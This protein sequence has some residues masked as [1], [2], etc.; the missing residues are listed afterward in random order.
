MDVFDLVAKLKMDISEYEEGLDKAKKS[1][2]KSGGGI[3]G[4]LSK[5][6]SVGG[7][8]L[9]GLTKVTAAAVGAATA[10]VGALVKSS[11]EA[12]GEYEQLVGGIETLFG[13]GGKSLQEYA[14]SVGKTAEE[15]QGEYDKLL[16]TQK[17]MLDNASNAFRT[18]GLSANEYMNTTIGFSGALLKSVGGDTEKAAEQTHMAITDMADQANKYGKSV[19][20]ISETYT[21]L[22]R[23]NTQTLD[24]LFGGMFAGTKAGLQEMLT[25]AEDYRASLGETVS[26][27][28]DSY[29]DIVSAIHDVSMATGVYGTTALEASTTIQG[30][31][32]MLSAAWQNLVTGLGDKNAD[33][34][35]LIGNVVD[36]L[37]GYTD[38]AGKH[39]NGF[40]DNLLPIIENSL[41]AIGTLVQKL[42]PNA[43]DIIPGLITDV[44]PKLSSA[45]TELVQGMVSALSDNMDTISSVISQVVTSLVKLLPDIIALGGKIATTLGSAIIDNLDI[46]LDAAGQILEMILKG[47][48][49]NA[50]K[51]VDV[52]VQVIEMLAGFFTDNI[53]LVVQS[54]ILIV[55]G[56]AQGLMDNLDVLLAAAF[57]ICTS[58]AEAIL[59]NIDVIISAIPPLIQAFVDSLVKFLPKMTEAWVKLM[60]CIELA[61]PEIIDAILAA[62][63]KLMD[64]LVNYWLGD[65]FQQTFRASVIMFGALTKALGMA[66]LQI[67]ANIGM[68]VRGIGSQIAGEAGN[69]LSSAKTMFMGLVNG[70]ASIAGS[71][72][73]KVGSL[74]TTAKNKISEG[75]SAFTSYGRDMVQNF[76]NGITE[77]L[78][79][80][81]DKVK[82]MADTIKSYLHFSEP[83]VGPLSD[84]HTYAPD[85]MDL[86]MKG[87]IDNEDKLGRTISDAF[88]FKDAMTAPEWDTSRITKSSANTNDYNAIKKALGEINITLY[89]TT[90]ID[91]Q[92]IK[93]DSYKYTVTRMGDETRA[94][95]VAMGGF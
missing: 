81:K 11:V 40:L 52:A 80:L 66:A 33:I 72:G 77:K 37:V 76:I 5:V 44:L 48:S 49:E 16:S 70:A 95:K 79:A 55:M 86:F 78:S 21:S 57:D 45:A 84:F 61:L 56:I 17:T 19:Q 87:I 39:V 26:Y 51:L 93:K 67:V 91:G 64:T 25:Y 22:A 94:V 29:A 41:S 62:L 15:A 2:E 9:V 3:G 28:A 85:M 35:Q 58:L 82:S 75:L 43:L 65:G 30:S 83:D 47:M 23:G 46:I 74:I 68:F 53:D 12:Y 24:N 8:A 27:S 20:E 10:G 32:G 14:D 63:P 6:A 71:L 1:A 59:N 38:E 60:D 89:N 73:A 92:A 88:D 4:V 7:K 69:I 54:A 31:L 13:A 50:G 42:V 34:S 36:S 18:A 90:E